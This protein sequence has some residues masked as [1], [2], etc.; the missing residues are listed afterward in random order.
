VNLLAHLHTLCKLNKL[1]FTDTYLD[2]EVLYS[3]A[4]DLYDTLTD[5]A[6]NLQSVKPETTDSNYIS[7]SLHHPSRSLRCQVISSS[8]LIGASSTEM[9]T[10][11]APVLAP[12]I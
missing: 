8:P 5:L 2:P 6:S 11:T 10:R 9:R 1:N 7:N 4:R 12:R 3:G